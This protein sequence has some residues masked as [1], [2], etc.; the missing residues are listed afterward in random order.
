MK[1]LKFTSR[2][3]SQEAAGKCTQSKWENKARSGVL[4]GVREAPGGPEPGMND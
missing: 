2:P 3:L 4:R 1:C